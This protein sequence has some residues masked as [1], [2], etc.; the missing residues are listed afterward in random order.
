MPASKA[1]VAAN[2]RYNL[3]TYDNILVRVLKGR[4]ADVQTHA[5]TRNESLNGFINRAID[6]TMERDGAEET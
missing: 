5:K 2:D 3:K 4:K 6:E 1:R